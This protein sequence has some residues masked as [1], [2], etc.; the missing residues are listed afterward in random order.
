MGR[1]RRYWIALAIVVALLGGYAMA[2]FLAVPHFARN[3]L[4][5][6]VRTHYGRTLSVGEIRCNPFTFNLD[7]RQ[8]SL[9][10]A[11][12]QKLLSFER[13]HLDL[14]LLGSLWRL[15]PSFGE[16]VL[17]E[18]YVR[19]VLRRDG[20]LNLADLGKGFAPGPSKPAAKSAPLRLYIG[21]LAIV[22][23]TALFEDRTRPTP[24]SAELKPI[25]FELRDFST[26][27]RTA[28]AYALEA[29]SPD[30][31]RLRWTGTLRLEPL[32]SHG[33]F[34]IS[35]L[36][37]RTLWNYARASLPFE[38]DSGVI[39]IEGEY[40]VGSAGGP[41]G[42]RVRVHTASVSHLGVKPK[43]DAQR[44]I[45]VGNIAVDDTRLDL[46]GHTVEVAKVIV[47]DG[48]IRA[49]VSGEGRLNLFEL[50]GSTPAGGG[51]STGQA[52]GAA[53]PVSA[54]PPVA[55]STDRAP[56]ASAWRVSVP[57]VAL[58][59]FKV[60]VEDRRMQPA[61][62]LLLSPLNVHLAG[63]STSPGDTLDI[64]LDARVNDSGKLDAHAQVTPESG[65][66]Q[67]HLEASDLGLTMLQPYIAH[68][69]SMTLLQGKLGS[70]LDIERKAD[71]T[72][73]VKGNTFVADLRTVDNQLKQ[74]FVRWKGL[75]VADMS[76]VSRPASLRIGSITA[77]EPY[78]RVIVAP[79]RTINVKQVLTPPG[80][81]GTAAAPARGAAP[82]PPA[83]S[84]P[85][86]APAASA[87][88]AAAT[89]GAG[90]GS[91]LQTAAVAAAPATP[92][93]MSIGAIRLVS[94]SANYADL[95][96]KPSFA[97]GIQAL[98]G[99]VSGLSSDPRS[100]AKV[101]L[102][103]KVERYS[104]ITIAGTVN[105]LSAALYTDIHMSFKDLDLTVVNPYSGYFT[106]YR[107]DKGKLS[108]DVSYKIDQRK[109]AAAQHFVVDQLEIGD[110]VESPEATH[111]PL[112]LAVA[113][114]R[115]RNGLIDLNLPMSGSLDDPT[116][117]IG[118]ILWKIFVNLVVK[119]ATAPFALL[120][121]LFGGGE[122]MNIVE[123]QPGSA[124]LDDPAK[125][126]LT[127]LE[128]ALEE[129][130]QLKLDVPIVFSKGLDRPRIAAARLRAE[131]IA[132]VQNTREGRRHPQ[133]AGEIALSDPESHFNLLLEQYRADLGKETPLPPT[134]VAVQQAKSK[135]SAQYDPAIN[136]LGAALI[137]HIP[138]PD[139]D[140]QDL[141]KQRAQAIQGALVSSGK[142][143][144]SRV[145]I[146]NTAP[147]PDSG[148]TV[149]VELAVK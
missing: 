105:L 28:D 130:P 108:V 39:G 55:A 127:S 132:R 1:Y 56:R 128:K 60:S 38:I 102:D 53:S 86:A 36:K 34:E 8:L 40:D 52:V 98:G 64:T 147:Q 107:I 81:T 42:V 74:D 89:S 144:A 76:Y 142:V 58:E 46:T 12:G 3:G 65:A 70:R 11:D 134:A 100:R 22:A 90:N 32:L 77:L 9:P 47:S 104:P 4:Q 143:E 16:I 20:A 31:E 59:S 106:G 131:L 18:P 111:L 17:E 113:L 123:F 50:L 6:F 71:G 114:L 99:T 141:G 91:P 51:E 10:D 97:I 118:P 45:D 93:P 72:L 116:F 43:G 78:A 83:A 120:G 69:T 92:F 63:F 7:V 48:D 129:R 95:W 115:D 67:A 2:G 135:E 68:Y 85:A 110:R 41:L 23:G 62:T 13:L 112:K 25:A 94:G 109:L 15:A 21:R 44:Y 61:A 96:I 57:E 103:G 87:L 37:A 146:V 88:P 14:R 125:Q 82:A 126:Q 138:V 136:D 26:T 79:D 124:E 137:D 84:A 101:K 80:A 73:A 33:T 66:V 133:T 5:E 139:S 148:D 75:R 49:W 122:H 145:F 121:H 30:G 149:K 27:G 29:A 35:D 24:F 54:A 119:A 140:L 117:R 19:A